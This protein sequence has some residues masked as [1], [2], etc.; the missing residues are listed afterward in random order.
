MT[1]IEIPETEDDILPSPEAIEEVLELT[2]RDRA[3][4]HREILEREIELLRVRLAL[5]R[6]QAG[7][8]T[9]SGLRCANAEARSRLST[10]P[11]TTLGVLAAASFLVTA[12]IRRAS[13]GPLV[14]AA[15]PLLVQFVGRNVRL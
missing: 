1:A 5:V 15:T 14:S 4:V 11:W 3:E 13:P 2:A 6:A 9:R 8:V 7:V 10:R 12:T